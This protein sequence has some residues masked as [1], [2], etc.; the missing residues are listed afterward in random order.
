MVHSN[1]YATA[2]KCSCCHLP[3]RLCSWANRGAAVGVG[4]HDFRYNSVERQLP[5]LSFRV[6]MR[7]CGAALA[8]KAYLAQSGTMDDDMSD[9]LSLFLFLCF[10]LVLVFC[11]WTHYCASEAFLV[12]EYGY[13]IRTRNIVCFEMCYVNWY[14]VCVWNILLCCMVCSFSFCSICM[15]ACI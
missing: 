9:H 3:S 2:R 10:L 13:G 4:E 12:Q 5:L 8:L 11:R 1:L 6:A 15:Y 7:H 14:S